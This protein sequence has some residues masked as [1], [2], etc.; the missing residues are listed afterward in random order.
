MKKVIALLFVI[1]V[2]GFGGYFTYAQL[3]ALKP[4]S[5][6][7]GAKIIE[8][9]SS[10]PNEK[11]RLEYKRNYQPFDPEHRSFITQ[12]YQWSANIQIKTELNR[13]TIILHGNTFPSSI[14][15]GVVSDTGSWKI[16]TDPLLDKKRFNFYLK[17]P[18]H[19]SRE[20]VLDLL[21]K[22]L[23]FTYLIEDT[24]ITAYRAI[25]NGQS[26]PKPVNSADKESKIMNSVNT[27]NMDQVSKLQ[28]IGV[29]L[30]LSL[31][32]D[33]FHIRIKD[34]TGLKDKF[35]G[36]IHIS[37]SFNEAK[38]ELKNATGIELI[39]YELPVK[40]ITLHDNQNGSITLLLE[41]AAINGD[42]ATIQ[43]LIN[44]GADVNAADNN[45]FTALEGASQHGHLEI[46][47][48]LVEK[49]ANVNTKT[50]KGHTALMAAA[51]YGHSNIVQFLLD[52]GADVNSSYITG[53]TPLM[54]ATENHHTDTVKMLLD[55]GADVNLKRRDGKT[56]LSIAIQYHYADLINLLKQAG[57]KE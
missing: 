57:A 41:Y 36:D 2:I 47:R 40:K 15:W 54:A 11:I 21:A 8:I 25:W 20:K 23:E 31:Y 4:M 16:E 10:I 9:D 50:E 14:I 37:S 46:V 52:K 33:K 5:N 42:I 45:G 53:K 3:T 38:E 51:Q 24:T 22:E 7:E 26:L 30:L 17:F 49:G 27:N 12:E 44:K 29:D 19:E 32:R 18:Y 56:A 1:A 35:N 55:K 43:D 13:Q 48:L 39:P 6:I 34:E 28:N